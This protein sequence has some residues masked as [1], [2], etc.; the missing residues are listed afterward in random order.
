MYKFHNRL[1]PPVF[2]TFFTPISQI[3][4]YNTRSVAKQSYYL[5]RARTNY[6]IFNIRFQGTK[7]WNSINHYLKSLNLGQFKNKYKE[8]MTKKY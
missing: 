6:G 3:H 7:V 1:L 4:G 2:N 8:E 5:P